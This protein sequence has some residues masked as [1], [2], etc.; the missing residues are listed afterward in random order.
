MAGRRHFRILWRRRDRVRW[1]TLGDPGR[2]IDRFATRRSAASAA[3]RLEHE[4]HCWIVTKVVE[5]AR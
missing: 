3:V 1:T 2:R 4:F 5:V